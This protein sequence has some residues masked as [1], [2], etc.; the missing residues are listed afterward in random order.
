MVSKT[1]LSVHTH[2]EKCSGCRLCE[3]VCSTQKNPG[4]TNPKKS[5]IR[6]AIEHRENRNTPRMCIQC[7]DH[8]CLDAC[9]VVAISLKGFQGIPVIDSEACTGCE[10]CVPACPHGFMFFDPETRIALKCDLCGGD[11]E[12]VKNCLQGA[13]TFNERA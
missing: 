4:I 1:R 13:I 6:I 10:A 7:D 12:C 5:R 2:P 11:P 8:P 9:P 3:L